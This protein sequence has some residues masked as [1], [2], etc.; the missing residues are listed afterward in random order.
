M[1]KKNPAVVSKMDLKELVKSLRWGIP[2]TPLLFSISEK[3]AEKKKIL[4]M[5]MERILSNC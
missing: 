1:G 3:Y 5:K 2:K 4:K